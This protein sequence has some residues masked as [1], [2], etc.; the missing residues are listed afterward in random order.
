MRL[1]L[2]ILVASVVAGTAAAQVE[3]SPA[4]VFAAASLTD[5]FP[6]IAAHARFS[7]AGSNA[8][9]AQIRQGAPADVFASA[10]MT[11]PNALH[12]DGF[13]SKP[14]V[15][16]RNRLVLIVPSS[17]P[18]GIHSVYDLRRKGIKLV[19]ADKGFWGR[20]YRDRLASTGTVLLTPDKT[21]TAANVGRER[22]LASTRLVIES[23]FS[24]LKG[25]MRLE[26][27]FAK[28]PAGLALRIAQRI[29]ALTIGIL[30]NT[31]NGCPARALAAY[32]GR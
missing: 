18:A 3:M 6:K 8:L 21:R 17:N 10:N 9:A 24:N 7:F 25:Q 29:L 2:A 16:A 31:L 15:F 26:Q 20:G 12:A 23:V 30:L 11:L 14:V 19:I 1:A 27:H 5:P 22:A 13:C 4:T 28:T 32:D